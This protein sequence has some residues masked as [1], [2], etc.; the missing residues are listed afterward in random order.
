M[1]LSMQ[2][3]I[4]H[5][6]LEKLGD[7][8]LHVRVTGHPHGHDTFSQEVSDPL[9]TAN[10][11]SN[12]SDDPNDL[13]VDP[14]A[15]QQNDNSDSRKVFVGGLPWNIEN[16]SFNKLFSQ[17]GTILK[18]KVVRD[19][20][21]GVSRG[22]GF[23]TFMTASSAARAIKASRWLVLEGRKID[24]KMALPTVSAGE[25]V[26][27]LFVGGLARHVTAEKLKAHFSQYGELVNSVVMLDKNTGRS[28]GFGFVTFVRKETALRVLSIS[29]LWM[30]GKMIEVRKAVSRDQIDKESVHQQSSGF[31]TSASSLPESSSPVL[32]QPELLL[33]PAVNLYPTP[34]VPPAVNLYPTPDV[35][36]AANS[37]PP[38]MR[39]YHTDMN[40]VRPA[41]I[42][43]Q[44]ANINRMANF[45]P[46]NGVQPVYPQSKPYQPGPVQVGPSVIWLQQPMYLPA[47]AILYYTILYYTILYYTILYYTILLLYYTILYY[48]ILFYTILYYTMLYYTTL[49]YTILYYTIL[50]YTILYIPYYTILYYTI[51]YYTILYYSI[52]YNTI[53]MLCYAI[54]CYTMLH[55]TML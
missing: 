25:H 19:S 10:Y 33:G 38:V 21:S 53:T 54:L 14:V 4:Y 17:F 9:E 51:L 41:M 13:P 37:Y 43:Q 18:S 5:E 49:Y 35:P 16:D 40:L 24:C 52:L 29:P 47:S 1:E 8:L 12:V 20:A 45:A 42:L 55:C 44:Q 30:G 2:S 46:S 22:F 23:V 36:P 31:R 32:R 39:Y 48:S 11:H 50:Y 26:R 15:F 6:D 28:R 7:R 3:A 34:D 27:K